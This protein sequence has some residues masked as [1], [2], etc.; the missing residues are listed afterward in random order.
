VGSFGQ[1]CG[2]A[3]LNLFECE[4]LNAPYEVE[5]YRGDGVLYRT[6]NDLLKNYQLVIENGESCQIK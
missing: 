2:E 5:G 4:L 6:N 1:I 3:E